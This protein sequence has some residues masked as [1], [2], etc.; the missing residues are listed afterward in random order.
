M[1][2]PAATTV[3]VRAAGVF[4][5]I[6]ARLRLRA[7]DPAAAAAAAAAADDE[8]LPDMP[9][10]AIAPAPCLSSG[11][12]STSA[13]VIDRPPAVLVLAARLA[14]LSG[15]PFLA[16]AAAAPDDGGGGGAPRGGGGGR[17]RF[18]GRAKAPLALPALLADA[19]LGLSPVRS[20]GALLFGRRPAA[21][22]AELLPVPVRSMVP[23]DPPCIRL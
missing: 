1:L 14:M 16:A 11:L 6:A 5:R 9:V 4:F 2:D 15:E 18:L 22:V 20:I 21:A 23:P 8:V 12:P 17:E 13:A 3:P 19:L 10:A 7:V